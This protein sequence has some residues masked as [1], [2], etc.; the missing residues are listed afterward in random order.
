MSYSLVVII[1][2]LEGIIFCQSCKQY[3]LWFYM[4]NKVMRN[5][6]VYTSWYSIYKNKAKQCDDIVYISVYEV[7]YM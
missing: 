3:H 2:K 7:N 4:R 5:I 6:I 1:V